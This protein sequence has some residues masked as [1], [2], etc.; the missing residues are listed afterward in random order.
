MIYFV[1]CAAPSSLAPVNNATHTDVPY[2][3]GTDNYLREINNSISFSIHNRKPKN[4][5]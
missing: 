5:K 3:L 1:G 4:D 2:V